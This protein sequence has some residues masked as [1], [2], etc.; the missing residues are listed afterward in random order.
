MS[1]ILGWGCLLVALLCALTAF[2]AARSLIRMTGTRGAT[3]TLAVSSTVGFALTLPFILARHMQWV[4]IIAGVYFVATALSAVR[5]RRC[6]RKDQDHSN[7]A[8]EETDAPRMFRTGMQLLLL[9]AWPL[10]LTA[11]AQTAVPQ[12]LDFFRSHF[13]HCSLPGLTILTAESYR[14]WIAFPIVG[15]FLACLCARKT[16][17]AVHLPTVVLVATVL[18]SIGFTCA[19]VW[20]M[21]EPLVANLVRLA[22]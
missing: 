18:Y 19:L 3:I 4:P 13:S 12:A 10:I 5:C 8:Q 6:Q 14:Y 7:E 22:K 15:G 2:F 1:D 17:K 20:G 21:Y 16:F 9:Q 11:K